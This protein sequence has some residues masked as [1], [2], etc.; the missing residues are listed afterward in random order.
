MALRLVIT[1]YMLL[2]NILVLYFELMAIPEQNIDRLY[3]KLLRYEHHN[4]N[5]STSLM[6][7]VTPYGL[8]IK[9]RA[10]ISPISTDFHQQWN[11]VLHEA[12]QKLVTLLHLESEKVID[13][14]RSEFLNILKYKCP[15]E[16]ER[17]D[18]I[19][20]ISE[21]NSGYRNELESR[22]RKKWLK[23]TQQR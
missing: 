11:E 15:E 21:R 7:A 16:S 13:S 6:R 22:R 23:F 4:I 19:R 20:H 8:R 5:Y 17:E 14:L 10:Q 3:K 2:A 9:Q 18:L 12:E 1:L